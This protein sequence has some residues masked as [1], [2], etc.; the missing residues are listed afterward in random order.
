[1]SIK[2]NCDKHLLLEASALNHMPCTI[3]GNE[4]ANVSTYFRPQQTSQNSL[5][6]VLRSSFRGRPLEGKTINIPDGYVGLI[7]EEKRKP[8]SEDEDRTLD[9]THSFDCFQQWYLDSQYLS[10]NT[11]QGACETWT[12]HIA[13]AIHEP[14]EE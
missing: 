10:K 6:N 7:F 11:V 3:D 12:R 13:A 14:I 4:K 9:L 8:F 1:M 5:K 2:V